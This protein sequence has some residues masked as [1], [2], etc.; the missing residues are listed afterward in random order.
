M[1][2]QS[3]R[4]FLFQNAMLQILLLALLIGD[5]D[6]TPPHVCELPRPAEHLLTMCGLQLAPVDQ[7][8]G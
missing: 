6:L 4:H 2:D 3:K 7:R 5:D 1:R 8:A